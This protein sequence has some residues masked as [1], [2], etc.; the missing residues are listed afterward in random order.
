[1]AVTALI[2]FKFAF[3][4]PIIDS[5]NQV[6]YDGAINCGLD[7]TGMDYIGPDDITPPG[8]IVDP[9][10]ATLRTETSVNEI[11]EYYAER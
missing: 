10:Q 5:C 8:P 3:Y 6:N 1:M 2:Y 7:C 4:G 9:E 11:A